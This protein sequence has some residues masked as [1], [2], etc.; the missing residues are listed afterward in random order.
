MERFNSRNG[1]IAPL[2]AQEPIKSC[3]KQIKFNIRDSG[4]TGPPAAKQILDSRKCTTTGGGA[5]AAV[6]TEI[7]PD[8][9]IGPARSDASLPTG[10]IA[11]IFNIPQIT[12]WATSAKLDDTKQYPKFMRT[13]PTDDTVAFAV[14][15]WWK[16]LGYKHTAVIHLNDAYGGAY[17]QALVSHSTAAGI[18][19]KPFP[20][21]EGNADQIRFRVEQ[22]KNEG[23]NVIHTVSFTKGFAPMLEH[24]KNIGWIGKQQE[25]VSHVVSCT[26]QYIQ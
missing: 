10:I 22:V 17:A 26:V 18:T 24:A 21:A 3:D 20:Y 14:V 19:C 13:I 5:G 15:Q 12:Y 9:I 7:L 8:A 6:A 16:S 25:W 23:I 2:F 11:G 1:D 4:S